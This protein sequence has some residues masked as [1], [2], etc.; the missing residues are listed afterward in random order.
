[1]HK[2]SCGVASSTRQELAET[3]PEV[4]D[5]VT[6]IGKWLTYWRPTLFEYGLNAM[7]LANNPHNKLATHMWV[8][9]VYDEWI[10][11]RGRR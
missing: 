9:G 4:D 7:D 10:C 1:M 8:D 3:Q 5:E 6:A 11:W 2:R